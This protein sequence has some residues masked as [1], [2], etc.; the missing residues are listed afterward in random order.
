MRRRLLI[1]SERR[2]DASEI[3][4]R[5]RRGLFVRRR[6]V[7]VQLDEVR[8]PLQRRV[9]AGAARRAP[10]PDTGP[11]LWEIDVA[12]RRPGARATAIQPLSL[13]LDERPAATTSIGMSWRRGVARRTSSEDEEPDVASCGGRKIPAGYQNSRGLVAYMRQRSI[14]FRNPARCRPSGGLP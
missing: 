11:A 3:R 5:P 1:E 2:S 13:R 12:D 14:G 7:F 8:D 6:V 4:V 10:D 9:V